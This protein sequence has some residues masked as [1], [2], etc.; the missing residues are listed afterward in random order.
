[1]IQGNFACM[2]DSEVI[3]H[4]VWNRETIFFNGLMNI[5]HSKE[6][7]T[8][9]KLKTFLREGEDSSDYISFLHNTVN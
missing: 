1:M 9:E 5:H 6:E 4:F 8:W 2:N 3:H 7:E